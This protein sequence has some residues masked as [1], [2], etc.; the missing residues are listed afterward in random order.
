MTQLLYTNFIRAKLR[1][2]AFQNQTAFQGQ[3]THE[4][5]RGIEYEKLKSNPL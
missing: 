1:R 4:K 3:D 2:A 5:V